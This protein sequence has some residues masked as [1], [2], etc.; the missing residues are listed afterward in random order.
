MGAGIVDIHFGKAQ[1]IVGGVRLWR[2]ELSA[3]L[4]H[5]TG[6]ANDWFGTTAT[7]DKHAEAVLTPA[8]SWDDPKLAVFEK[9]WDL[10]IE[11]AATPQASEA[12]VNTVYSLWGDAASEVQAMDVRGGFAETHPISDAV[13]KAMHEEYLQRKLKKAG[14]C[15]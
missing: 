6:E 5:V 12:F 4:R 11:A 1:V 8:V 7:E 15:C 2:Y 10:T 13:Y 14:C 3:S 9:K